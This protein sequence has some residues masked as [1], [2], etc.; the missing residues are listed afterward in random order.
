MCPRSTPL[1]ISQVA[2]LIAQPDMTRCTI[3]H[4]R[5]RQNTHRAQR[6]LD[7]EILSD[8]KLRPGLAGLSQLAHH[9]I[10]L[11]LSDEGIDLGPITLGNRIGKPGHY[12]FLYQIVSHPHAALKLI[13]RAVSGPLSVTRQVCGYRLIEG[14]PEEIPAVRIIASHCGGDQEASYLIVE[15]LREGRWANRDVLVAPS[16]LGKKERAAAR[17]L[18]DHLAERDI[19]AVDCHKGNMF[20]FDN[21]AGD[22]V[23]GILD[24]DYISNIYDI[25][26][27]PQHTVKRL[28][29]QAGP[30]GSPAWSVVD[31]AVKG[32]RV[33][34]KE[35]MDVFYQV[36]LAT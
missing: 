25:P 14:F 27:L 30:V 10:Q 18:Y 31:R 7:D 17:R 34:T 35:F 32:L 24:H 26:K 5:R 16:A 28:F 1:E 20:F 21:G 3:A 11:P 8:D 33:S 12:G 19:I 9:R 23:A 15:N 22:F 4:T 36:K 6:T 29:I 13:H 2:D